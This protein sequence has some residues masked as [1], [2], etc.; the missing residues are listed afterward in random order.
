MNEPSIR[1]FLCDSIEKS[2]LRTEWEK[3]LRSFQLY[4][5]AEEVHDPEK[6]KNKLLHLGGPQL[7]EV[8]FNLPGALD[9]P[10]DDGKTD[11]FET[12]T[13]KL[14]EYFSPKRN[15]TFE[16]HLFRNISPGEGEDVNKF[17]LRL[18]HQ[19]KKCSFGETKNEIEEICLKDKIID[20]WAPMELKKKLLERERSLAE[21][22]EMYQ[23]HE[24]VNKHSGSLLGKTD[25]PIN[26]INPQ[27]RWDK[28]GEP[29]CSRCGRKGHRNDNPNCPARNEKC[30]KCDLIG[31]F[32][33]KCKT[34]MTKRPRERD[35]QERG[36]RRRVDTGRVRYVI[37]EDKK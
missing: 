29:E 34:K 28:S 22:I 35:E 2:M 25:N 6:K 19:V 4:L 3:W 27:G 12:L 17:L 23:I 21:V 26:K 37:D 16:R 7:Q 31:H 13:S 11:K 8:I 36:K 14:E 15:S 18:R 1:P 30:A 32:A 20:T 9:E 33:R 10:E 5:K 24:Q